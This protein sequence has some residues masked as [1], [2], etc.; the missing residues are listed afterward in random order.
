MGC[1]CLRHV[2]LSAVRAGRRCKH[3]QPE[4]DL[5]LFPPRGAA[6]APDDA[7]PPYTHHELD[8]LLSKADYEYHTTMDHEG[9]ECVLVS[10]RRYRCGAPALI[11]MTDV[12]PGMPGCLHASEQTPAR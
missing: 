10:C 5:E 3:T 7:P 12:F 2:T 4:F 9:R 8:V 11:P 1:G 6:P